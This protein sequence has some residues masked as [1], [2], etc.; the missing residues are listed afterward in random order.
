MLVFCTCE[1]VQLADFAPRTVGRP[2]NSFNW[3]D[4]LE[5]IS[6]AV[7]PRDTKQVYEDGDGA[8][9][10]RRITPDLESGDAILICQITALNHADISTQKNI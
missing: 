7:A 1:N 3:L 9:K 8:K 4:P 2:Q 10:S 6:K 5:K